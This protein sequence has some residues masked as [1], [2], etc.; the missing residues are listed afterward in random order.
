MHTGKLFLSSQ[1]AN[2]TNI[3]TSCHDNNN[4]VA[5]N[6]GS[7]VLTTSLT[8]RNDVS[9]AWNTSADCANCHQGTGDAPDLFP[10]RT[11]GYRLLKNAVV[12][13]TSLDNVCVD[14]H[15]SDGTYGD[16]GVG[17]TF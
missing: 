11:N 17:T 3:C 10:H 13:N 6:S 14:C 4:V 12:D 5:L 8:L 16:T 15:D 1:G 2:L 7:H 9:V